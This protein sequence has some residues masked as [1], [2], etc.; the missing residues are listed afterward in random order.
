MV[1]TLR[2]M[3]GIHG[4]VFNFVPESFILPG[5][6]IKFV[7]LYSS[8]KE[9]QKDSIWICKPSDLSRGRK[10]F[11]F[12]DLSDLTYDTQYVVQRYVHDPLLIAGYKFDLRIYVLVTSFH[13]LKVY[14]Y[15]EGLARF[16][17]EK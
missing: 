6:Y 10:I 17:T 13:P 4:N 5:E 2:K 7:Q 11:L 8:E 12:Q 16:S 15:K 1:R 14:L 3:K 9:E